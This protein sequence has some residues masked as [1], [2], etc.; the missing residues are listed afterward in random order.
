MA[1]KNY[2]ETAGI[3]GARIL[4]VEFVGLSHFGRGKTILHFGQES[5][6]KWAKGDL[7]RGEKCQTT[8]TTEETQNL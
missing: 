4:D 2:F 7:G 8:T 3:S 6:K 1:W 5:F